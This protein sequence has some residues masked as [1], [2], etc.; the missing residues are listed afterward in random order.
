MEKIEDSDI[1]PLWAEH[2]PK[3]KQRVA[4]ETLCLT[5]MHI[6]IDRA[7]S[8]IPY[9]DWSDKLHHALQRFQVPKDQ[10]IDFEN[11]EKSL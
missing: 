5:L 11:E 4:S 7:R 3:R 9:G 6:V 8:I 1:G 10:F 2:Y